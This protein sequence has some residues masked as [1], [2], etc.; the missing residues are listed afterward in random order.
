M[1]Q[2]RN[3]LSDQPIV[4]VYEQVFDVAVLGG[5]YAG[6]AAAMQLARQGSKVLLVEPMADLIWESG[7]CF[8]PTTGESNHPLFKEL[9]DDVAMRGGADANFLDGAM[10]EVSATCIL[11]ASD[12]TPLYYAHPVAVEQ[13]GQNITAMIVATKS[14]MRRIVAKQ[15]V[16]AS[17]TA[18]LFHLAGKAPQLSKPVSEEL[19]LYLQKLDWADSTLPTTV[20]PTQ[21]YVTG[22][23]HGDETTRQATIRIIEQMDADTQQ[24]RLS[25]NSV[26][27]Y[28]TYDASPS[29]L[30]AFG[31]V[32]VA[33]P[34]GASKAI[35]TLADRFELGLDAIKQLT[36]L[37]KADVDASMLKQAI[38]IPKPIKTRNTDVLV[39]GAGTGGAFA[40]ICA[41]KQGAKVI[42]ADPFTYAGGIGTGGGIHGYYYGI[43]G[44]LQETT[45]KQISQLMK[46][47][48]NVLAN[49]TFNPVA[50]MVVLENH[51]LDAG[52][53]FM[54]RAMLCDVTVENGTVTAALL[55]TPQ[56]PV[57][58]E[59]KAFIDGTGD[60]DLCV[61]A[62]ADYSYGRTSDG[63][64]HAYSQV[65]YGIAIREEHMVVTGRNFD[66][67]WCDATDSEDLTR[68][69]LVGIAQHQLE[70]AQNTERITMVAPAIGL[71]QTRQIDTDYTLTFNDQISNHQFDDVIGFAGSNHD[72]H[73]VDYAMESDEAVFWI[74][75][76]RNWFTAFA[77]PLPYR[78]LLPK[79]LKNVGIASRCMG[80]TQ[81]AHHA[82]RMMRDMQR[83]GEAIGDAAAMFA[84]GDLEDLREVPMDQLQAKLKETGAIV[85]DTTQIKAVW[86]RSIF[87]GSIHTDTLDLSVND[88]VLAD[89]LEQ[90]HQGEWGRELWLL[91]QNRDAVESEVLSIM[92]NS[93]NE[94]ARWFAA[95]IVGFWGLAEAEP[96]FIEAIKAKQYGYEPR[97]DTTKTRAQSDPV[98]MPRK[99]PDWMSAVCMLRMCGSDA[100]LDTLLDLVTQHKPT[101]M[102]VVSVFTTLDR[103]LKDGRITDKAKAA[104]IVNAIDLESTPNRF[105]HPQPIL[106][107]LAD[108]A[109][110]G[111]QLP[112]S[113]PA[114]WPWSNTQ[115]DHTW[116]LLLLKGRLCMK[117]GLDVPAQLQTMASSD[118]RLLVRRALAE[119]ASEPVGA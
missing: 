72:T 95:G 111:E 90:L 46:T 34:G 29:P 43:P 60:G 82:T 70:K 97:G 40:A 78:I 89:A 119:F 59:A 85:D 49:F 39:I 88:K 1:S 106:S 99:T 73:F 56:G 26:D 96:V 101:M 94:K 76:T 116:R 74:N 10:A 98:V 66:A 117:L 71:R 58:V 37:P 61:L 2:A 84:A 38:D 36:N 22:K 14:G 31:N 11:E 67:G 107:G 50:K 108:M 21:R 62:G 47:Y 118:Q 83:I 6:Y 110:R 80:L 79:T 16:D 63:L 30:Q 55:T 23:V 112:D 57:A 113:K 3:F 8:V 18:T 20:W 15:F 52:V 86:A 45:D 44:G 105:V 33:V 92:R 27:P 103:M 104:R 17:E 5:G 41:G 53:D 93:E 109:L 87:A 25:H 69:R 64:P 65:S 9:V 100:C 54:S 81:D 4:S 28:P 32:A 35:N 19:Y 24:A 91:A 12:V 42:C 7:R 102:T 115:E 75:M 68:A 48:G 13:D 77:H 51:L 114:N